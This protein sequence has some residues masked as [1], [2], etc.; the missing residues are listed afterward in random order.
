MMTKVY[1]QRI[2]QLQNDP[3]EVIDSISREDIS[4]ED[5]SYRTFILK[6]SKTKTENILKNAMKLWYKG[7]DIP[8]D[9]LYN[10]LPLNSNTF[11]LKL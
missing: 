4:I 2:S 10:L 1:N 7:T 8:L 5:G 6:G 11:I 9:T 3:K